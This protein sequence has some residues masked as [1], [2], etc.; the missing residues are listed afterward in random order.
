MRGATTPLAENKTPFHFPIF[1]SLSLPPRKKG[2]KDRNE[3]LN[4]GD[5][6]TAPLQSELEK[7][8]R[9][10]SSSSSRRNE[11]MLTRPT[12]MEMHPLIY[13][14][15][16]ACS[17]LCLTSVLRQVYYP[18]FFSS[19]PPSTSAE[20][21]SRGWIVISGRIGGGSFSLRGEGGGG[22]ELFLR[23]RRKIRFEGVQRR[24]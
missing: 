22:G 21:R 17:R 9:W 15:S 11:G 8:G 14:A 24:I 4:I 20:L 23:G 7:K 16:P 10:R 18:L 3:S 2:R 5:C 19:P 1:L 6:K 12:F 13:P